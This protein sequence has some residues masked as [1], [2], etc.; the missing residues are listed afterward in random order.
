MLKAAGRYQRQHGAIDDSNLSVATAPTNLF[1]YTPNQRKLATLQRT[2]HHRF[3]SCLK[4]L[5]S[6][7]PLNESEVPFLALDTKEPVIKA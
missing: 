3:L 6:D 5:L 4:C 7:L 2:A 1:F